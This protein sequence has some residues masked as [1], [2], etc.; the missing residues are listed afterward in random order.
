MIMDFL[1]VN[2]SSVIVVLLAIVV[3]LFLL[4]KGQKD[5]VYQ[6]LFYLVME[7]EAQ[8]GGGTGLLKFSAVTTWLYDKMPTIITILFSAKQIDAM[9]EQAVLDMKEYL[10]TN[11]QARVL[12][13][14]D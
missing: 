5:T 10:S 4:K 6:M 14:K 7:A 9:I 8:F 3:G 2:W 13:L 11:S 1:V 12:I